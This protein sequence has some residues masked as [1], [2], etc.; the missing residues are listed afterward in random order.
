VYTEPNPTKKRI[1]NIDGKESVSF[2]P[3]FILQG[4]PFLSDGAL[5]VDT[6]E[7]LPIDFRGNFP[8]LK[9]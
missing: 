5:K 8:Y 6:S 4:L 9:A 1:I 3:C 7:L 2:L